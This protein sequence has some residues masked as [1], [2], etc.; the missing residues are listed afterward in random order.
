MSDNSFIFANC[1]SGTDFENKT[2]EFL[3]NLKFT[4]NRTGSNDGGIDIVATMNIHGTEYKF[5]IQCKCYNKVLG[6]HPVQEV[7][8]GSKYY[9]ENSGKGYPVLITNNA[10]T[11]E[12]RLY[13]KRLGVEVIGDAEWTEIKRVFNNK[14][15]V[16]LNIHRGLM[17]II[18]AKTIQLQDKQAAN[19]YLEAAL[20][21]PA[22]NEE[23]AD[24]EELILKVMNDFDEAEEDIKESARL[25]QKATQF[26]QKG[27]NKHRD[28]IIRHLKYG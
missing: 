19:E 15:A 14:D 22:Y 18:I 7:F 28:A 25:Y 10:V 21:E 23:P 27:L 8:A 5:Y 16:D 6:K 26:Q 2:V 11:R 13:A 1:T 12:A 20:A 17:G 3:R 9:E 4:T 24:N